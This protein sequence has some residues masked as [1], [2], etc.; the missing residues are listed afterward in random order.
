MGS[1][2]PSSSAP[3]A[4]FL[5]AFRATAG[6]AGCLTFAQ[7]MQLALYHP[8]LGYYR[9]DRTRVGY[10]AGT[11]FFTA[12]TSGP[13]FG[14]IL[15]AAIGTLLAGR[16]P[17]DFSF[18]EI[19]A[20]PGG[21]ILAGVSHPFATARTV[22]VGEPPALSGPCIVF[23]NELFDA[24][25]FR[26][27]VF[28]RG[29]WLEVNVALRDES[30]VFLEQPAA[31]VTG[32]PTAA[33][34]GYVI[35]APL[36]AATLAGELASPP[37]TGLFVAFDY[38]KS[39]RELTEACPAGTARAYHRHQQSN[40]LLARPG[41]QDLTC[42]I[43]WDWLAAALSAHGFTTPTLES[44]EAFFIHHAAHYIATTTTA[45][46]AHFSQKKLSLLQLLHPS[47]LG[48]KFQVLHAWRDR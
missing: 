27:F 29:A 31:P 5:A 45:E 18:V 11:D 22:Q 39:W 43:C 13:V 6:A 3:A 9:R 19:G 48:Q 42:H 1:S 47:H 23:S 25:P 35:D 21:G 20:E 30:L 46:A 28:R 34:E 33:P 36:A 14:E 40:D 32:L 24:Q 41:E 16:H 10:G 4:E 17:G 44:Q 12:S 8:T 38:G 7:F 2:L 37:W 15:T 26:R